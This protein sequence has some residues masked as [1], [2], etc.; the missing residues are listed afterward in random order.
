MLTAITSCPDEAFS[1]PA[2]VAVVSP[3]PAASCLRIPRPSASRSFRIDWLGDASAALAAAL[4]ASNA[5]DKSTAGGTSSLTT[6]TSVTS[7]PATSKMES[8]QGGKSIGERIYICRSLVFWSSVNCSP[9]ELSFAIVMPTWD[10]LIST[11]RSNPHCSSNGSSSIATP[12]SGSAG[13][14]AAKPS[15]KMALD[16]PGSISAAV[17]SAPQHAAG[18]AGSKLRGGM[19]TIRLQGGAMGA[20]FVA[21]QKMGIRSISCEAAE[22]FDGATLALLLSSSANCAPASTGSAAPSSGS[23]ASAI[24]G[25]DS[26]NATDISA[27]SSSNVTATTYSSSYPV[28]ANA[29]ATS[30]SGSSDSVTLFALA[31]AA[32]L[33]SVCVLAFVGAAFY[34]APESAIRTASAAA[35][36]ASAA[37]SLAAEIA[38]STARHEHGRGDSR[39]DSSPSAPMR[40]SRTPSSSSSASSLSSLA[41]SSSSSSSGSRS[42]RSRSP[43][44]NIDESE[45]RG[46]RQ[47]GEGGRGQGS[48]GSREAERGG[49]RGEGGRERRRQGHRQG[50]VG[51]RVGRHGEVGEGGKGER[52]ESREVVGSGEREEGR[53]CGCGKKERAGGRKE[54]TGTR[55]AGGALSD[56]LVP[57]VTQGRNGQRENEESQPEA[58]RVGEGEGRDVAGRNVQ[59]ESVTGQ[60]ERE[61]GRGID[62]ED[63]AGEGGESR[64]QDSLV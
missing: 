32:V 42:S 1:C 27:T 25:A 34:F 54:T 62:R 5:T 15:S 26:G 41:A 48:G 60:G 7:S 53:C 13:E 2:P 45:S 50:Q 17:S 6:N 46:S 40:S 11:V 3:S 33:A 43:G 58:V 14:P 18:T 16:S 51:R 9:L 20:P 37:A 4:A 52:R 38:A 63:G 64:D 29:T 39:S 55:G 57:I 28:P 12:N 23:P 56:A 47:R 31:V 49:N 8:T 30:D 22:P 21:P 19:R 44:G 35:A 24:P 61:A 10:Y 59:V 36:A